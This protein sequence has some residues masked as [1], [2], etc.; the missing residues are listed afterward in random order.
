[1]QDASIGIPPSGIGPQYDVYLPYEQRPNNPVV[2]NLRVQDDIASVTRELRS[3]VLALAPTL[4]LYDVALLDD[5]L[6]Q[7]EQASRSL[8]AVTGA[9]AVLAL[10]LAAFG[11]FAVLAQMVRRRTQE[12][13]IRMAMGAAPGSVL[14]M[15]LAEGMGLSML[16]TL[17][18]SV[19]AL[20]LTRFM[21]SLL[22]GVSSTDPTVF[23]T[24]C[25][26]LLAV[27]AVAC[28]MPALR[29]TRVDLIIALR[30]E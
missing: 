8:A 24:I 18:G 14:R 6:A 25:G 26:A 10:F 23:T 20:L 5:R 1:M 11:L 28:W 19:G 15:I 29:A 7:Q 21:T 9:Y 30:D 22:F 12:I 17:A 13:G 4:P 3:A 16:G 27:T 2:L